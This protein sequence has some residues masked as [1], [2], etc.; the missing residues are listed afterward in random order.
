MY[1]MLYSVCL[2]VCLLQDNYLPRWRRDVTNC[3]AVDV[4]TEHVTFGRSHVV[5]Q[6]QWTPSHFYPWRPFF[7]CHIRTFPCR[8]SETL[9]PF[10]RITV[11]KKTTALLNSI[12]LLTYYIHKI[13]Y[14]LS[15]HGRSR[16]ISWWWVELE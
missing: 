4:M 2:F 15:I 14:F 8:L 5:Y 3:C 7:Q 10:L 11:T 1:Y 12:K 9:T 13:M 6:K 16:P